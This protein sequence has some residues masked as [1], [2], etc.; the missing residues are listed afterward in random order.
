MTND[1]VDLDDAPLLRAMLKCAR[2]PLPEMSK[3]GT[4]EWGVYNFSPSTH[5]LFGMTARLAAEE[6]TR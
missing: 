6:R 4:A 3:S 5:P 2:A 1:G